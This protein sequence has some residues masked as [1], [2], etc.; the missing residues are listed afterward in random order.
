MRRIYITAV[1]L[2]KNFIIEGKPVN[3][4]NFSLD[5]ARSELYY[6]IVPVIESTYRQ[7][8][9][10]KVI[11]VRQSEEHNPNLDVLE[12]ELSSL[13]IDGLAMETVC[14]EESQHSDVL[15]G[16]FEVLIG[17][18]ESD[19]AYY[20]DITFGTKTYPLIAFSALSYA[21][22]ILSNTEVKG[23]YY[24]EIIREGGKMTD[25][26]LY[27]VSALFAMNSIID[28]IRRLPEEEGRMMVHMMLHPEEAM[29]NAGI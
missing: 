5:T 4:V 24:Q 9:S 19:S 11:T 7:G 16:A 22:K 21:K 25:A 28:R 13:G 1:P 6:P 26:R 10:V 29:E 15:L 23:I 3:P 18:M 27:D 12:N 8:D 14:L 20:A 17:K 2:G